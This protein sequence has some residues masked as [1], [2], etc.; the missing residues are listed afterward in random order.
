MGTICISLIITDITITTS[1]TVFT[2]LLITK[3]KTTE[4]LGITTT[5]TTETAPI[6]NALRITEILPPEETL[7]TTVKDQVTLLTEEHRG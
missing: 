7:I 3:S 4:T 6:R 1:I 5:A 2:T